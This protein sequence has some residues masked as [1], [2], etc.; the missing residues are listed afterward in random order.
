MEYYAEVKV[1]AVSNNGVIISKN[2]N[3]TYH[4][5]SKDGATVIIP[6]FNNTKKENETSASI[7]VKKTFTNGSADKAFS[8]KLI[9]VG[10]APMPE[11]TE[12]GVK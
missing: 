7:N 1:T 11:G 6:T 5:G 3:V 2:A 12:N 9:P 4:K 8:F 10:N